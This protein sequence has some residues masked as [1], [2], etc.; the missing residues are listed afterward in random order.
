MTYTNTNRGALRQDFT[1]RIAA[2]F[3]DAGESI[4]RH[5]TYRHTM[6]ELQALSDRELRDLAINRSMIKTIAYE[7]AYG[8]V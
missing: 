2:W 6:H 4:Q 7:A 5:R 3:R 1:G 8:D